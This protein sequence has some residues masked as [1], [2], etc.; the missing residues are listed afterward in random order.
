MIFVSSH[1]TT[2]PA[3]TGKSGAI[4]ASVSPSVPISNVS[5]K[6]PAT[7]P[8]KAKKCIDIETASTATLARAAAS[9]P[10][11]TA[12]HAMVYRHV[13]NGNRGPNGPTVHKRVAHPEP[14]AENESETAVVTH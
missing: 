3:S 6:P 8:T 14:M 13:T 11:K 4:G 5:T 2:A 1:A 12:K 10:G 9:A 7:L